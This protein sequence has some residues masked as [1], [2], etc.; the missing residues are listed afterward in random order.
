MPIWVDDRPLNAVVTLS[1]LSCTEVRPASCVVASA[2]KLVEPSAFSCVVV[3]TPICADVKPATCV[4]A[5][6]SASAAVPMPLIAV[7]VM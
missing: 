2:P 4:V 3:S 7:V 5:L 6:M 1:P